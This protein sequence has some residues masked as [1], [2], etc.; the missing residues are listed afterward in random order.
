ML[1]K[2]RKKDLD[3]SSIADVIRV[4]QYWLRLVTLLLYPLKD[5]LLFVL[6][7]KG[8]RTDYVG[9]PEDET[10]LYNELSGKRSQINT[11][12]KN[13]VLNQDQVNILLPPGENKTDSSTFDVTLIIVLITNFTTLPPP[14]NGWK[15]K[16]DPTDASTAA[17]VFQ[18]RKWR[19]VLI[20]GIEPGSLC[21]SDFDGIWLKGEDIVKGLGLTTVDMKALK[22]TNLDVRN[23]LVLNSVLIYLKKI[24]GTLDT[25]DKEFAIIQGDS[26]NVKNDITSIKTDISSVMS[27]INDIKLNNQVNIDNLNEQIEAIRLELSVKTNQE[28]TTE[29]QGISL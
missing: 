29:H 13:R 4:V 27:E 11:L 26:A 16:L 25:H 18:A 1:S 7:N 8:N 15:G 22:N 5:A 21:K 19:N 9:L 12:V 23:S 3:M 2:R 10:K 17:F 20:H 6:H 28:Y 24:Q 14:K